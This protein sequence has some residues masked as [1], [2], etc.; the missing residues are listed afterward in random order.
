[1]N[2]IAASA[3]YFGNR[4]NCISRFIGTSSEGICN[5]KSLMKVSN[6]NTISAPTK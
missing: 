4:E 2:S 3:G 6:T 5:N 1:M